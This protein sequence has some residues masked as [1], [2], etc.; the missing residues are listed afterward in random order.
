MKIWKCQIGEVEE[1]S[2]GA[3]YPMRQAVK[4]AYRRITGKEPKFCFSGW[5]GKLSK[6]EK[7]VAENK[8]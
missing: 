3:D 7:D 1:V 2:N 6:T 5:N 8:S 4:E